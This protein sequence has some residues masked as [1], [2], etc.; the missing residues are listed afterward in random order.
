MS[1]PL[2][3]LVLLGIVLQLWKFAPFTH[4]SFFGCL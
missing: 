1:C 3:F 4:I 2:P